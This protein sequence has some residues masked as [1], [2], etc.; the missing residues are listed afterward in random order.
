MRYLAKL[1]ALT[2]GLLVALF[3]TA[4][5]SAASASTRPWSDGRHPAVWASPTDP[6]C[7]A[8]FRGRHGW[9]R[10]GNH[11]PRYRAEC[12]PEGPHGQGPYSWGLVD[13]EPLTGLVMAGR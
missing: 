11:G 7:L 4:A 5:P 3:L 9:V 13:H 2:A 10:V 12:L 6:M 8:R 1:A